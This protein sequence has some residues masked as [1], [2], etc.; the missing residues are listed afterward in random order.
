MT[1]TMKD[2]L[3]ALI[4]KGLTFQE[5]LEV[6]HS[7]PGSVDIASVLNVLSANQSAEEKAY[8]E[9][10]SR[11]KARDGELEFD[12]NAIT[13]TGM[14]DGAYVLGW[15]WVPRV[16]AGLPEDAGEEGEA[17]LVVEPASEAPASPKS[18]TQMLLDF[19]NWDVY[20]FRV[21]ALE[22]QGLTRSDAQ[23]V[24]DLQII[25]GTLK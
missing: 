9:A 24:V 2:S 16:E 19:K 14:D 13:S 7:G 4:E 17:A 18:A 15:T 23:G 21:R 6:F 5:C 1:A 12:A 3:A 25:D 8:V 22:G 20:E 10:A 11:L